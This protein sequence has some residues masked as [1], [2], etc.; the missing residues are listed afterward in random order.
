MAR[1]TR[2]NRPLKTFSVGL[3]TAS[4]WRRRYRRVDEP[5]VVVPVITLRRRYKDSHG[6]WQTSHYYGPQQAA[7]AVTCLAAA[8]DWS[9]RHFHTHERRQRAQ[10]SA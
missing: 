6:E 4:V 10:Q 1:R 3:I 2:T 5:D 7:A 8:V 9:V